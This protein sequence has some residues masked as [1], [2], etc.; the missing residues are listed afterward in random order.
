MGMVIKKSH[1]N[2]FH[3]LYFFVK[4]VGLAVLDG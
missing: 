3:G 1:G 4:D 2:E